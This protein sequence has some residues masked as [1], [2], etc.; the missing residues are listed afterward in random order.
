M[1]SVFCVVCFA[2][3]PALALGG[4]NWPQFHGPTRDGQTDATGLPLK[5]SETRNVVWKTAIEGRGWSSPVIWGEQVWL[6]TAAFDGKEMFV[7]CVDAGNGKIVRKIKF[8]DVPDPN[9][10]NPSNSFASP[11]PAIEQGRLYGHFGSYGTACLDTATGERIWTRDDLECDHGVGPGSSVVLW[12]S[13]VI[14][15]FDGMDVQYLTALDK[16][17]G[18]TVWKTRR[19]TDFGTLD[20]ERRKAFSTPAIVEAGG[21]RQLISAGAGAA[22]AY[23]PLTGKELW[24][25]RYPGGFSNVSRP[26]LAGGLVLVN[27]G[28]P[29]PKLL[30]VRPDGTGDVTDSHVAWELGTIIPIKP[31]LVLVD[32]RVY[33]VSDR[34]MATCVEATS[35]K[36]L[37]SK[38]I[39]KRFSATPLAA[40]GRIYF[41]D[42]TSTTTV[43]E[44]GPQF[45]QLAVN[46][47]DDGCMASPAAA[48]RALFVRTRTAL[49]RIEDR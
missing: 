44:P 6:T 7:L 11:T 5:W 31:S 38:G 26:L 16:A 49:Y 43:I 24:K 37:W 14:L 8:L 34:G 21:R 40:P 25:V 20:G 12:G 28:F 35:G 48:G 15:T 3:L 19:T 47:L 18:K 17:T 30:A 33:I 13:L 22:M 27:S 4:E 10:I 46:E 2:S 1:R 32:G 42:E 39:G 41:F 36:K 45:R 9:E 29:R 23:D